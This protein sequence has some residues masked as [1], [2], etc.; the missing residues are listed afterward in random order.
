MSQAVCFQ[1]AVSLNVVLVTT[2]IQYPNLCIAEY[3]VAGLE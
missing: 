3:F 1:S 2:E